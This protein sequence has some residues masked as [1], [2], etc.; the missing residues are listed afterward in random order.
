MARIWT[1]DAAECAP[2]GVGFPLIRG[3]ADS[4]RPAQPRSMTIATIARNDL[5][6]VRVGIE[7]FS[8]GAAL[9]DIRLF[10]AYS[11]AKVMGATKRAMTLRIDQVRALGDAIALAEAA[12]RDLHLIG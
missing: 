8:D 10:K 5:S 4:A 3:S 7:T 12:A 2:G 1:G 9:L 11:P 6:E